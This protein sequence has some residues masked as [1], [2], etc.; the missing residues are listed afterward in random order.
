M[1]DQEWHVDHQPCA[2]LEAEIAAVE[3]RALRAGVAGAPQGGPREERV[4]VWSSSNPSVARQRS[5]LIKL[6]QELYVKV[7][8]RGWA[9]LA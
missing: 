5:H 2:Q 4:A 3:D 6:L 7:C 9:V 8:A 1:V